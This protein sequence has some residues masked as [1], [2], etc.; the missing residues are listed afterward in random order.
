[1][2]TGRFLFAQLMD[3]LPK[4]DFDRCVRKYH[5]NYRT[6]TFSCYD[7]FLCLAFA[8][9][10]FRTSLR[11]IE[12][13][14]NSLQPKLYHAG[15]RGHIARN[16]LAKANEVR[17][18]RIYADFA[19][20][21]ITHARKLYAG[22][23]LAVDL[24]QTVY[25]FDSTTI[26]LCLTLFPWARFRRRKAA[27]KL[28]T[29]IDLRGNI[30]C[31]IHVSTGKMH[32]VKALDHLPLEPG[33]FYVMDRGYIDFARL[34]LFQTHAAFFVTRAKK[35]CQCRR[36]ANRPVDKSTGLRCDQTIRLTGQQSKRDYP[37][38][39]RRVKYI[40]PETG[41]RFVFLTNNLD[42]DALTIAKLY[43]CR[44]QVEL[45]FKWIKQHLRI[46][47][48]YGTSENAVKTQVWIAVSIYVV[49]AIVRKEL[50]LKRSMSEILQILSVNLFE[51]TQLFEALSTKNVPEMK[52]PRHNPL[53][54]F[55]F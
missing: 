25:A 46:K 1:M 34:Y 3:C 30:P 17:D 54:L 12:I 37:I 20:I 42:L 55:D 40:D 13:C 35:N 45:F 51:K 16:T 2:H 49:V 28:H 26:D 47:A 6:R 32:D 36:I 27:V 14:L 52:G 48:F 11:D 7:Q 21:L 22:D 50:K 23:A 41:K 53:P 31:F 5:G 38:A 24:E 18:W 19:A 44:W 10:T 29:L 9:L 8:Q 39:L 4:R 43:K 33:A 15:L